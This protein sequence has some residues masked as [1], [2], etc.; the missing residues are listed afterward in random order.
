[1]SKDVDKT[2]IGAGNIP[3]RLLRKPAFGCSALDVAVGS[4]AV[5]VAKFLLE[6]LRA[7]PTR[8]TLKMGLSCGSFELVRI[9]WERPPEQ[10]GKERLDLLEVACE[11]HQLELVPWLFRDAG[12]FEKELFVDFG[13]VGVSRTRC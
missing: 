6:F 11:F 4:G 8:E 3:A 13:S 10:Q 1:M 12:E 2:W 9:C 7:K 5:A